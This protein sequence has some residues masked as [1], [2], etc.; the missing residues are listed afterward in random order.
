MNPS[1]SVSE[2]N[3]QRRSAPLQQSTIVPS[4]VRSQALI[5]AQ[6]TSLE[7][8]V[9]GAPL[10]A[11]LRHLVRT[12]EEQSSG[13]AVASIMLLDSNGRLRNGGSVSLPDDY[14]QAID[15]L[16]AD[17]NL[18]TCCAAAARCE[19]V[20]TPDFATSPGWNGI[21]HLPIEIGLRGAW[22]MPIRSREGSVLG[23][24]GTYFRECREPFDDERAIVEVLARTAAIAIERDRAETLRRAQTEELRA[25]K[26][27]AESANRAKS[28]FLAVMSHELRTPLTG[29]IG[30]ADLLASEVSGSLSEV[31]IAHLTRMKSGAWHLVSIID[32]ILTFSRIEAGK[33][34]VSH[35]KIDLVRIVR[36]GA[37]LMQA[38]A[39]AKGVELRVDADED[40]LELVSDPGKVRQIVLN[41]TGNALKFTSRGLV[42]VSIRR[43]DDGAT[44]QV[45]DTGCG[46]PTELQDQI[47]EPFVQVDQTHSRAI[48][49][50]G[51]GLTVCRRL[52][53][54][55]G[56]DVWLEK[57]RSHPGVGSTFTLSIPSA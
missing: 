19:V 33:E 32:E 2:P 46:I 47:F 18:G 43:T 21:S 51:L 30:Y 23:T 42:Q 36:D 27:E 37:E 10:E 57:S 38:Q 41:L 45:V 13:S 17:P 49:G 52:A 4:Y 25:A 16:P 54:L 55:L 29:I 7:M 50:T 1:P 15:G 14:L 24:F 34:A 56:G 11:V 22:S 39:N 31:Q 20:I 3:A 48:G 9:I 53:R 8:I 6:K 44:V 40:K 12:V 35:E 26:E 5:A 28:Q